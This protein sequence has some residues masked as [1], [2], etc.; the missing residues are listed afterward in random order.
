MHPLA[1]QVMEEIGI[2]MSAHVPKSLKQYQ[3]KVNFVYLISL[4][5]RNEKRPPFFPGTGIRLHWEFE[6]PAA[7]HGTREEKLAKFREMRD[8]IDRLVRES[9]MQ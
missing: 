7:F 5:D 1:V 9:L 4:I 2:D 3:G 6:N 8:R